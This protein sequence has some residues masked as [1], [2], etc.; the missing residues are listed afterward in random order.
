MLFAASRW[1]TLVYTTIYYNAVCLVEC[2]ATSARAGNLPSAK[3]A[4]RLT[5][6]IVWEPD[7][8]ENSPP[9]P[10]GETAKARGNARGIGELYIVNLCARRLDGGFMGDRGNVEVAI[11]TRGVEVGANVEAVCCTER[12]CGLKNPR[13]RENLSMTSVLVKVVP[14]AASVVVLLLPVPVIAIV[15]VY[16]PKKT[17]IRG[18]Y[19]KKVDSLSCICHLTRHWYG[20][21]TYKYRRD[22]KRTKF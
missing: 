18:L 10:R 16:K 12:E 3:V 14:P 1:A 13:V 21:T 20:K 7:W 6:T 9:A 8:P 4:A 5:T 22:K 17:Q 15:D 19:L 2:K 11:E